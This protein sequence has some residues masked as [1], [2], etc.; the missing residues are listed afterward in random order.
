MREKEKVTRVILVRHGETDFPSNRIYCDSKED[1]ELNSVGQA[2][3]NQA[4]EFL[5][6]E[7]VAAIYA[8][9]CL[10]TRMTAAAIGIYHKQLPVV[11]ESGLV[12]RNF[13]AWEGMYFEEIES[14]HPKQYIEWKQNQ[15]AFKPDSGGESV[16]DLAERV[17]PVLARIVAANSGRTVVVVAHVGPIRVL[18]AR[19]LNLPI[20]GYR[21][22]AIDPASITGID[23]G[24]SQNN[25]MFMNFHGR[26]FGGVEC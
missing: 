23:Y 7:D 24:A 15:A 9:P 12:E 1:P 16:Y 11:F 10:R 14:Q 6:A 8:S 21:Q 3:A 20:E 26:H 22:L 17:C 5:A 13:G 25:L 18:L 2:Q 4:A 19:A